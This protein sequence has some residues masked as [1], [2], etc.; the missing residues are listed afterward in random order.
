[1]ALDKFPRKPIGE[2]YESLFGKHPDYGDIHR[3]GHKGQIGSQLFVKIPS[4][5]VL[6]GGEYTVCCRCKDLMIEERGQ[7]A[8]APMCDG[9]AHYEYVVRERLTYGPIRA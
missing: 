2:Y 6:E 9:S 8:Y 4:S 7:R 1:M 3:R 5:D